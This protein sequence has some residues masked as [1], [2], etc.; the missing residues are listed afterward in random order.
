[1]IVETGIS[2]LVSLLSDKKRSL[3]IS[4]D[5]FE[6]QG[7]PASKSYRTMAGID[8]STHIMSK[9]HEISKLLWHSPESTQEE[10]DQRIARALELYE[11]LKPQDGAEGMLALQMVGTHDAALECLR[12][13]ALPN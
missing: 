9:V 1:M 13:A 5:V 7:L 12:R 8:D 3:E 11:S 10:N 2:Q 6:A 4:E